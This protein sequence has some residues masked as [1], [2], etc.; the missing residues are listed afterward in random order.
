M[1]QG[2][3]WGATSAGGLAV[4]QFGCS[5][6][7]SGWPGYLC[8]DLSDWLRAGVSFEVDTP[9]IAKLGG[10]GGV[11]AISW[12][13]ESPSSPYSQILPHLFHQN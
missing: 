8:S 9:F 5:A 7:S 3:W 11:Q 1:D 4:S 10:I 12:P 6:K 13:Q 2:L